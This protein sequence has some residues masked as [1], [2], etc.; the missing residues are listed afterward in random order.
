MNNDSVG[1]NRIGIVGDM[2]RNNDSDRNLLPPGI[3]R[4]MPKKKNL[5]TTRDQRPKSPATP[6]TPKTPMQEE[7]TDSECPQTPEMPS[8]PEPFGPSKVE[9]KSIPKS[10]GTE[11]SPQGEETVKNTETKQETNQQT[12]QKAPRRYMRAYTY[13]ESVRRQKHLRVRFV[14]FVC[15]CLRLLTNTPTMLLTETGNTRA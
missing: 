7:D 6:K 13:E 4:R 12:E 5:V 14:M 9:T 10:K 2:V 8:T 11:I 1:G 15:V 3:R